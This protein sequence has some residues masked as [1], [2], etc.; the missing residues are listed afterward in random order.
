MVVLTFS[1]P[2]V[3]LAQ[4][5]SGQVNAAVSAEVDAVRL[6]A[7]TAAE[8]DANSD[9]NKLACFS[10]GAG[11]AIVAGMCGVLLIDDP[12]YIPEWP[13]VVVCIGGLASGAGIFTT[14]IGTYSYPPSPPPEKLIGKSLEYVMVYAEAYRKK[15]LSLR[16]KSAVAGV[17]IGGIGCVT[18][19]SVLLLNQDDNVAD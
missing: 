14:L 8:S 3:A 17:A 5:N 18:L 10:A 7:I 19:S 4:Q 13:E 9:I 11:A 2:F 1:V 6:A 16:M 12:Y 15:T